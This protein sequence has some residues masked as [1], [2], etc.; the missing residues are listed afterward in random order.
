MTTYHIIAILVF[1][2]AYPLLR[3]GIA[4]ILSDVLIGLAYFVALIIKGIR[5]IFKWLGEIT[6]A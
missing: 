4:M 1:I 2:M 5:N 3:E 6:I